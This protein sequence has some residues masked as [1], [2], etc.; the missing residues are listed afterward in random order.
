MIEKKLI[1]LQ[2]YIPSGEGANGESYNSKENPNIMVKLYKSGF[3]L[4]AILK[5]HEIAK[6]VWSIGVPSPE[7]GELVTDGTRTGIM[8][9][10]IAGK[11]SFS[12]MFAD[13][14]ERIPELSREFARLCLK[15]H[16]IEAPEGMFPSAQEDFL[17]LLGHERHFSTEQKRRLE[18]F[19][20][21]GIPNSKS[22][23]HGDLHFGNVIS[24]LAKGAPLSSDHS[25]YFIDLGFFSYGCPLI[26]IGMTYMICNWSSDD[27]LEHD[28]HI[29]RAMAHT[30]WKNFSE[31][32]FF[33]EGG[34]AGKL[35]PKSISTDMVAIEREIQ[36]YT[37]LKLLL[38]EFTC[39]GMPENYLPLAFETLERI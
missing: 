20:R 32:Y 1:D 8:F 4:D 2:D 21:N 22:V 15:L 37:L 12:R 34:M 10:R 28:F 30:A 18:D 23:L 33:G 27:F 19:I 17:M 29:N 31:E 3:D 11:R 7:P 13:E 16:S 25:N 9:K 14:P 35:L 38:V 24:T 36:K 39:N 26:D 5:E 6:K